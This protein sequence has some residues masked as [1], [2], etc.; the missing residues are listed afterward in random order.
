M[1][2]QAPVTGYPY[3]QVDQ[4]NY[5]KALTQEMKDGGGKSLVYW[6]SAWITSNL[7]DLWGTGYSWE[8][9]ALFNGNAVLGMDYMTATYK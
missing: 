8:N 1:G 3:T 9:A 4:L 2:S 7:K 6:E 5:L